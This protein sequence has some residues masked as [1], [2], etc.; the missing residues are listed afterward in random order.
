VKPLNVL[1]TAPS[2]DARRNVSGISSVV[3]G[4]I[5]N[6]QHRFFHYELGRRDGEAARGGRIAG[7]ARQLA[8][9]PGFVRSHRIDLVHQNLPFDARGILR[10]FF[11]SVICLWMRVPVLLHVHGGALL[12]TGCRNPLLRALATFILRRSRVVVVLSELER[13]AVVKHFGLANMAV[14][15]N[16]VALTAP[17]VRSAPEAGHKLC[18][19]FLGRLH[20][21]KGL[22]DLV[23]AFQRLYPVQPF[24]FVVC[25]AGPLQDQLVQACRSLMGSDF[26]F[27]G[28]V[29]G[30]EK[31]EVIDQADLFVLPSRYGEG[32]PMAL[33]EAMGRGVVPVVTDDASMKVV[34]EPGL[35][36]IRVEKNNPSDIAAQ[37]GELLRS[38]E[39]LL[40]LSRAAERTVRTHYSMDAYVTRLDQLYA[41]CS[42]AIPDRPAHRDDGSL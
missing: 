4:I 21:S 38:P 22:D 25:G 24:R 18:L 11:I 10:E 9:F 29:A 33:L 20:E 42:G 39:R 6:S 7:L 15:A 26:E 17:R 1:I 23:E 27:K 41:Q 34:V 35:N 14:L 28:V 16:A 2:L 3:A 5:A 12:M 19:L 32:L 40:A 30:D 31:F 8:G 36:G 37:V 13:D